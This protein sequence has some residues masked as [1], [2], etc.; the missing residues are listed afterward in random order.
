[1][2][3]PE[4]RALGQPPADFRVAQAGAPTGIAERW[5]AARLGD[6]H[7]QHAGV[8]PA[9]VANAAADRGGAAGRLACAG[10]VASGADVGPP[11][12]AGGPTGWR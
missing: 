3:R 8:L 6:A 12:S 9:H 10:A 1:M 11:N 4:D 2:S 7:D 5:H